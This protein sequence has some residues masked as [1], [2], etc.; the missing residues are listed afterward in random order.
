MNEQIKWIKWIYIKWI[1][2]IKNQVNQV[3]NRLRKWKRKKLGQEREIAEARNIYKRQ[4]V[5]NVSKSFLVK[6]LSVIS[7]NSFNHRALPLLPVTS[8]HSSC[9][10]NSSNQHRLFVGAHELVRIYEKSGSNLD[11]ICMFTGIYTNYPSFM[12]HRSKWCSA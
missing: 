1:K 5:N 3:T 8:C 2:W 6:Y 9:S 4:R 10:N 12:K 7:T 11:A